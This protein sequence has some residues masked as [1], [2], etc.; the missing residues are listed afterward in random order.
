MKKCEICKERDGYR[1]S[2]GVPQP[3]TRDQ[4]ARG[5]MPTG[6]TL[7]WTCEECFKPINF[8]NPETRKIVKPGNK[9][10]V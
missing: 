7:F 6:D 9:D 3:I 8:I 1:Y 10:N 2:V 4:Q 5:V